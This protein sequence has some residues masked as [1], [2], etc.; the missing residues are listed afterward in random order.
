MANK[1]GIRQRAFSAVPKP[2]GAEAKLRYVCIES[3]TS[4]RGAYREG[5]VLLGSHPDVQ[6]VPACWVVESMTTDERLAA[7][8][9]RFPAWTE[10]A[11]LNPDAA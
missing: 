1:M 11:D 10:E 9:T 2:R 7:H 6:A 3:H 5:D 8:H 4:E